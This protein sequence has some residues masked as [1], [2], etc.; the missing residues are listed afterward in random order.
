MCGAIFLEIEFKQTYSIPL[1]IHLIMAFWNRIIDWFRDLSERNRLIN[2]FNSS[3]RDAF[4]MLSVST[5]LNARSKSGES[6]F[7]HECSSFF[8]P[9]GFCIKAT[10]G[11]SLTKD[12]LLYIGSVI[13][14]N[15]PLTR[16]LFILGWDT[17]IVEDIIGGKQVKWAIKDFTNMGYLLNG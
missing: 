13:L 14:T 4:T 2:E 5:L 3:A 17:L 12:E 7:R 15:E 10:A 9:T 6:A 1:K 8:L 16:R 11:R